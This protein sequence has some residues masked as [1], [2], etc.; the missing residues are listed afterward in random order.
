MEI[1]ETMSRKGHARRWKIPAANG[2]V[3]RNGLS[4][5]PST[6]SGLGEDIAS[7]TQ[8]DEPSEGGQEIAAEMSDAQSSVESARAAPAIIDPDR[9]NGLAVY[10][11]LS[12]HVQHGE[13]PFST[14]LSPDH[15]Q[16]G[17]AS[18]SPSAA[19]AP[20]I[21]PKL[22]A[23]APLALALEADPPVDDA[24]GDE[25]SVP[26]VDLDS[27]FFEFPASAEASF[28]VDARQHDPRVAR[29]QTA[30]AAMRRA[31]LA[32]Y[33][34]LAVVL[35][36]TLCV[37]ALFKIAV[38]PNPG[39]VRPHRSGA[40]AQAA[41]PEL[42]AVNPGPTT[43][44]AESPLVA[45]NSPPTA[46][47]PA[48]PGSAPSAAAADPPA[49]TKD[50]IDPGPAAAPIA[51]EPTASPAHTGGVAPTALAA[52]AASAW[53]TA[54]AEAATDPKAISK[55]AGKEKARSRSALE[56]GRLAESVAAGE[57]SVAIDPTDAEAWLILGAAYQEKG[58]SKSAVRSFRACVDQGK[59]GPK[60]E[61]AAM[62]H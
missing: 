41:V 4:A 27:S 2:G 13:A 33:V 43:E 53:S 9:R 59:R 60:G 12:D 61:C 29:K 49:P 48:V 47:A 52:S 18:P 38:T 8:P 14:A 19:S 17:E 51:V 40:A 10:P 21:A 35:A 20:Q 45:A 50:G 55:A 37:A 7:T 25:S 36:S 5:P 26:P 24:R 16:H 3:A 44:H 58:D 11:L 31:H 30:H 42:P 6:A 28:E 57:R 34:T 32:R 22:I 46:S 54:A 15:G 56:G 1:W 23:V 62:L 39:D